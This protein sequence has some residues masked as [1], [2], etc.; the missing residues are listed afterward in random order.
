MT[1]ML[2]VT[3][4]TVDLRRPQAADISTLDVAHSLALTNRFTGH[5]SRP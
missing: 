1:W 5:T 2:T 4:A 3:G